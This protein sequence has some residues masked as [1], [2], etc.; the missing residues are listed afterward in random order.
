MYKMP[1]LTSLR[2]SRSVELLS[3]LDSALTLHTC[4]ADN[5]GPG[6][7]GPGFCVGTE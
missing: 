4:E 7:R 5:D 3:F 6:S 1:L 2:L